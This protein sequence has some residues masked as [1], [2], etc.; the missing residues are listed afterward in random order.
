LAKAY[1]IATI[2]MFIYQ[3]LNLIYSISGNIDAF[4]GSKKK[5]WGEMTRK[6]FKKA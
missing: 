5:V 4:F 1:W 3:P 6:G 2:E